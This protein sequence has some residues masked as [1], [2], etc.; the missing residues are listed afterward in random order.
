M[1]SHHFL[2]LFLLLAPAVHADTLHVPKDHKSI[3][4]ALAAARPGDV[5]LVAAGSY[6]EDV[7]IPPSVALRSAG[8]DDKGRLGLKRAEDTVIE[9]SGVGAKTPAI[10][11]GE[12]STLD[13]FTVTRVGLFDKKEF[14]RH[15]ATFGEL[16]PDD[17]GA[18]EEGAAPP[19][20]AVAAVTA[21]VRNNVVRDNGGPGVGLWAADGK[22]NRSL[23]ADNV[24]CRNRGGGIGVADGATCIVERNHCFEN[25]RAG[26]SCR[27]SRPFVFANDCH[28]NVRAGIG[29][30]EGATPI[31]R[32]NKCYKNRRA[33]IGARMKGTDPIIEDNDCY[34][35]EMAGIGC[36]DG[37]APIIRANRCHHNKMAGIGC[38]DGARPIID[39]NDCRENDMAGIGSRDDAMPIVRGNKCHKN[40]MAG[41]GCRDGARPVV[42]GNE[43]SL[44]EMAGV[45]VQSGA[46]AL[47]VGNACSKNRLAGVGVE[48][49]AVA[50]VVDNKCVENE[51]VAVGLRHGS[52]GLVVGNE[53]SRSG[54]M[55]PLVAVREGS[56]VV[57][58]GNAIKGGGVAGVLVDGT[59]RIVENRMDATAG[60]SGS[61][62]WA[63]PKA[64][65]CVLGNRV[66]GYRSLIAATGC[67]VSACDN[68]VSNFQGTAIGVA[69]SSAPA[70]V[71]GN[72][73]VSADEKAKAAVV[74]GG[75]GVDN[76]VEAPG[77]E[78]AW[79]GEKLWSAL[80]GR[81]P[82]RRR[83]EPGK[84]EIVQ[85]RWK[86]IVVRGEKTTYHLYDTMTDEAQKDDLAQKM[87]TIAFRM[88]GLLER[89]DGAKGK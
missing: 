4:A 1:R 37:A 78:R 59:A 44:N 12:G 27:N 68:V 72:V 19:A 47:I 28:D 77:K 70:H 33:G 67:K 30:R 65:V 50:F 60:K 62:V 42:V 69:K 56:S 22:P 14:D 87:D 79:S 51:K 24:A 71:F 11:L 20:I 26:V 84:V 39:G 73:A 41:I 89:R 21:S 82:E 13:G 17:Q 45:G 58:A 48:E 61:A 64:D 85:G 75:K 5:V 46:R 32:G 57:L 43:C 76:V 49:G 35:N 31:V 16:M 88:R 10:V 53:L 7:R 34:D 18:V 23:V 81:T 2:P 86:L 6:R 52:V 66:D 25:L 3:R 63:Q 80:S 54:G 29:I 55:P 74:D 15:H 36:R 38:R 40:K 9:G 83:L 8:T